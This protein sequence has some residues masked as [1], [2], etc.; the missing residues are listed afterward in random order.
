[1]N[2]EMDACNENC[3]STIFRFPD[4]LGQKNSFTTFVNLICTS[5]LIKYQKG[6]KMR[7]QIRRILEFFKYFENNIEPSQAF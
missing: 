7:N 6:R 5:K 4:I 2:Y 3:Y 1:M